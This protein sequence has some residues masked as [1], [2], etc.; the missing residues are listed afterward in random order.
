MPWVALPVSAIKHVMKNKVYGLALLLLALPIPAAQNKILSGHVPREVGQFQ[1]QALG[2][3]PANQR[4]QLVLGLSLRNPVGLSNLVQQIYDPAS[5]NFHRY[6]TPTQFTQRFG[7]AEEDY[8]AVI[9]FAKTNGFDPGELSGDRVLL[10]VSASVS[11]IERAFHVRMRSYQHPTEPRQFYAPDIE[12]SV[13]ANV[14]IIHITGLNN[15]FTPHP[16]ARVLAASADGGALAGSGPGGNYRGYDFRNAYAPTV[17][18]TGTGQSVGLVELEGYESPDIDTY[19]TQAGLPNVNLQPIHLGSFPGV[20]SADTNGVLECSLDI[21]MVI[22][23]APGISTLYLFMDAP[24]YDTGYTDNILQ[25]MVSSNSIKQFSSSWGLTYDP[26][27][28]GYLVQMAVQGQSFFQASGDGDA[29]VSACGAIP[30]PS[31]DP[32]V[33][34]V[35]GTQLTMTNNGG[36]Y[37]SEAVWNY[38]LITSIPPWFGNCS[39]GYWGSGGGVSSSFGIPLWQQSV[40]VTTVGGSSSKRNIPDVA[41][42]AANVWV[43]Y[44]GT[45]GA[46]IGTSCAAPLWA[47]FTALINQQA[48]SLGLSS[49]GFLNPA[50]YGIGQGSL[51]SSAFNDIVVGNDTWSSS[52]SQ[53]YAASGYDLCTGWGTPNGINLIN[54]LMV[55]SGAVWVDYNYT[56]STQNGTYNAPYKTLAQAVTAVPTSGNIWF[57]TAGSKVETMTIT[58]AMKIHAYSGPDSVGD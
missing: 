45:K 31:D 42:T 47:G 38:G 43:N 37:V 3:L 50:L 26:M 46:A 2:P 9:N 11:A 5:T 13:D 16:M 7:P 27:A 58:K 15:F 51:Y 29:Y 53:F 12:P 6:L 48:A 55:Y 19:E 41:L 36:A 52:P 20:N 49:V 23:M 24:G 33:T 35:G 25:S 30:W 57:R 56:G 10:R 8:V 40:N 44:D 4:L 1:L 14:P 22:S 21:E 54:A 28:E 32:N 18:Q 39:S 34:S 17:T